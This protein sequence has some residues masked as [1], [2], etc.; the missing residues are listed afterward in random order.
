MKT[1]G[2]RH[3]R[4]VGLCKHLDDRA[5]WLAHGS[6]EILRRA[7]TYP[8]LEE[9]VR[10]MDIVVG[11]TA[12]RRT[13]HHDRHTPHDLL[14]ILRAKGPSVRRVALLFGR[15]DRGLSNRELGLCDLVSSVPMRT[16]YPSLNLAQAVMVYAYALSPLGAG[17]A[18][19][20]ASKRPNE[21]R[22][23]KRQSAELLEQIG[24]APG[25]SLHNRIMERLAVLGDGDM[26]LMHAARR[27][28]AARVGRACRRGLKSR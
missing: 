19:T 20:D 27:R 11:T 2:F 14:P 7:R 21:L 15:E 18:D 8:T 13:V 25:T 10:G 3:L 23:L 26:K 12:K 16:T 17:P 24:I 6:R 9:A 22:A 1:M 28:I 5:L 4:L